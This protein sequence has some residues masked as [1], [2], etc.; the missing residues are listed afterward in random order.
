V[1]DIDAT[2]EKVTENGGRILVPKTVIPNVGYFAM[3]ADPEG[4]AIGIMKP[5]SE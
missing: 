4:I 2:L 5:G 3:F 1:D